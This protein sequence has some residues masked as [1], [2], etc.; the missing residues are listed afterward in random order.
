MKKG[1]LYAFFW[2]LIDPIVDWFEARQ[3][4]RKTEK[5]KGCNHGVTDEREERE[6]D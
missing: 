2:N 4:M 3:I 6:T 5:R 1:R